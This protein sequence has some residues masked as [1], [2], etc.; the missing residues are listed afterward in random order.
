MPRKTSSSR[1]ASATCGEEPRQSRRTNSSPSPD[2]QRTIAQIV[3]DGDLRASLV[4]IRD[5][6]AFETDEVQWAR[7]KRECNCQC[8]MADIR[9]LVALTKRLEE[10]MAALEALP[11]A[12]EEVS[13]V[14]RV[15]A[16]SAARRDELAQRRKSRASGAPAS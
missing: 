11:K 8:G 13:E 4:A 10:T 9:T 1:T 2:S 6:L 16:A 14:E 12:P 15:R 3:P 7:H 5:R